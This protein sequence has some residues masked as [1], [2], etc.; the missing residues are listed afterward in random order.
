MT[1]KISS[2]QTSCIVG[3]G[4]S[5]YTKWG[6]IKD[7]SQFQVTAQAILAAVADAGLK[8][9][10]VDGLASFSNDANEANLMQVVLMYSYTSQLF[11]KR[12]FVP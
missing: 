7:R 11:S 2:A 6:G 3:I 5:E 4:Q 1:S 9:S 12:V 10:D 8:P